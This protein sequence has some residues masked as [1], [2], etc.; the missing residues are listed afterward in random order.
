MSGNYDL[1]VQVEAENMEALSD[2]LMSKIRAV[3]GVTK[4]NTCIVLNV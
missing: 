3:D 1:I 4:T 2:L